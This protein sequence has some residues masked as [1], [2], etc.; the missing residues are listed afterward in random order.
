MLG[1]HFYSE[2][3]KL[4]YIIYQHLTGDLIPLMLM[5]NAPQQIGLGDNGPYFILM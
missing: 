2:S 4:F 3:D 1:Q 5:L